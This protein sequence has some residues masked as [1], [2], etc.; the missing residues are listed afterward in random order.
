MRGYD[1]ARR[2]QAAEYERRLGGLNNEAARLD[3][4]VAANV[5]QDTWDGFMITYDNAHATLTQQV[6]RVEDFQAKLIGA[7]I[8][9]SFVVPALTG[10]IVY[11]L[12]K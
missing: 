6:K 9:A 12:T 8:L 11:V 1:E 2:L 4:A 7:F 10:V 5:S 3:Q